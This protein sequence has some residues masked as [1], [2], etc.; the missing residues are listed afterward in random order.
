MSLF[1]AQAAYKPGQAP[2]LLYSSDFQIK[3]AAVFLVIVLSLLLKSAL[4]ST[5]SFF[6][7]SE[8][9]STLFMYRCKF[10]AYLYM[11][12]RLFVFK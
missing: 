9:I 7:K 5:L 3:T 2:N 12:V 11:Y 1:F 8:D 4:I 10:F 6:E